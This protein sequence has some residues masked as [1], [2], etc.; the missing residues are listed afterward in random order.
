MPLTQK[1]SLRITFLLPLAGTEPIG[2]FKVAY[3]YANYLANQGHIVSVVHP[4]IFRI[5]QPLSS[6]GPRVAYRTIREYLQLKRSGDYK[7]SSWFKIYPAVKLLWVWSLAAKHIPDGDMVIGTAWETTEWMTHYPQSKG[8]Q[9]YLIQHL[10]TWSGPEDRVLATWKLPIQ[11]IAIARWLQKQAED[12]G[13]TAILVH[14]GLDFTRF[15]LDRPIAGRD[16]NNLLML[17][18]TRDWKGTPDGLAAFELARQQHP[19]LKLT[20]FGLTPAPADLPPGILYHHNPQQQLLRELYN[21]ASIFLSPSWAEGFPLP[22][23][24]ALQCGAALVSTDIDGTAMYAIHEQ[25]ALLSPIKD[26]PAMAANILRLVNDP[27]LRLKL[28][29]DGHDFI[30]QFTWDKAGAAFEAALLN[31]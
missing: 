12:L 21:H 23:A 1:K 16:P 30:Q 11:K 3:E 22:P 4:E 31:S 28:A 26:P 6:L 8:K 18:H 29:Q 13:Q 9:F 2:G 24:E 27:A 20:L 7:P 5:D 17:S 25:T 10:E 14:N 15:Q 19:T